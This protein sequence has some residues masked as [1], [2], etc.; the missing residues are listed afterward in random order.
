MLLMNKLVGL[1]YTSIRT[2]DRGMG[3]TLHG[4]LKSVVPC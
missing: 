1:H 4:E 3:Q 2:S